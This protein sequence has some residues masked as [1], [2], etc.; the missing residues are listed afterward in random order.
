MIQY[1]LFNRKEEMCMT[2]RLGRKLRKL[3]TERMLSPESVGEKLGVHPINLKKWEKAKEWP[4][5]D[6]LIKLALIYEVPV[7]EFTSIIE[8]ETAYDNTLWGSL[9]VPTILMASFFL[10]CLFSPNK[11]ISILFLI[12]I[13]LYR[14]VGEYL[15]LMGKLP[16]RG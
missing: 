15:L 9:P 16:P 8:L 2:A 3:R 1:T 5:N 13:P 10:V 12:M 6:T 14:R 7:E 11:L 4:D